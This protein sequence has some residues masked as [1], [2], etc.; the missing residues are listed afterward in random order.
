MPDN[1]NEM[2]FAR[3]ALELLRATPG[4]GDMS[5]DHREWAAPMVAAIEAGDRRAL[6]RRRCDAPVS[7][8]PGA[9]SCLAWVAY[10]AV[11][12][13]PTFM[14]SDWRKSLRRA[15]ADAGVDVVAFDTLLDLF[16]LPSLQQATQIRVL[17]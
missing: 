8:A 14:A 17:S 9:Y 5:P 15:A 12:E 11:V 6:E 1:S 10:I 4:W 3:A 16:P 2:V 7:G 13:R